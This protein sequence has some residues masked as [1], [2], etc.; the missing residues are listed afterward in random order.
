YY[1]CDNSGS[2]SNTG[3]QDSPFKTIGYTVEKV[4]SNDNY[5]IHIK[6]G[7]YK[8]TGNTNLTID[9]NTPSAPLT[10]TKS[11][12]KD[13]SN[14]VEIT[15]TNVRNY[16]SWDDDDPSSAE[17]SDEILDANAGKTF[18]IDQ[19]AF[20]ILKRV[21]LIKFS[22]SITYVGKDNPTSYSTL[23]LNTDHGN[24]TKV[25]NIT[26]Q[27]TDERQLFRG[28]TTGGYYNATVENCTF[29]ANV[30]DFPENNLRLIEFTTGTE[31]SI[32][33]V[34]IFKNSKINISAPANFLNFAQYFEGGWLG[35]VDP[36]VVPIRIGEEF[37]FA[38]AT[39]NRRIIFDSNNI[40]ISVSKDDGN[41]YATLNA[42]M[43]S[44]SHA[45]FTNNNINL[46]GE[47]YLYG[48]LCT[49]YSSHN[50]I[51]NN[52]F[53]INGQRYTAGIYLT[54]GY[55]QNNTVANNTITLVS[56]NSS[57]S[58]AEDSGYPIVIEDRRYIG[59]NYPPAEYP[60]GGELINNTVIN[61]TIVVSGNNVYGIEH[62]GGTNT[63][64]KGNRINASGINPTGIVITGNGL[65]VEDNIIYI[66]AQTNNTGTTADYFPAISGGIYAQLCFNNTI[67][68]NKVVTVNGSGIT[69]KQYRNLTIIGNKVN[70]T[71]EYAVVLTECNNNNVSGNEL[72]SK[73]YYGDEAVSIIDGQNNS[74]HDNKGLPRDK[75][76]LNVIIS[77]DSL[78]VGDY[79]YVNITL[80]DE[81]GNLLSSKV[82]LNSSASVGK[83]I[84]MNNGK[85]SDRLKILKFV[86]NATILV[87]YNG[88]IRYENCSAEV[89]FT[90]LRTETILTINNP[91]DML[92]TNV[93]ITINGTLKDNNNKAISNANI[94]VT[95]NNKEYNVTTNSDGLFNVTI[96]TPSENGKYVLT[97]R[98]NGTEIY[99]ASQETITL[100]IGKIET[101]LTVNEPMD[102]V[103]VTRNMT[104]NGT[105]KDIDN[106]AIADATIK[107]KVD[108]MDEVS[109]KTN[110][111]GEYSYSFK[112]IKT[113]DHINVH[114]SYAGD[115]EYL[116]TYA[117]TWFIV[118]KIGSKISVDEIDNV[119][120]NSEINI[121]G[122]LSVDYNLNVGIPDATVHITIDGQTYTT[123][124]DENGNYIKTI[125]TPD[126][127]KT[128]TVSV[129]YKGSELYDEC[130]DSINLYVKTKSTIDVETPIIITVV[131]NDITIKGTLKD[132]NG[133]PIR[134]VTIV[135]TIEDLINTTKTNSTG[136]YTFIYTATKVDN[137]I[138]VDIKF[139]G[140][141]YYAPSSTQAT[142]T[143]EKLNSTLI[144]DNIEN[145]K[146]NASVVITGKVTNNTNNPITDANVCVTVNN[147]SKNVTTGTDGTFR[148]EF[149]APSTAKTYTV[150]A[151]YEGSEIYNGSDNETTFDVEKIDSI[152]TI[153][154]IGSVDAN[155]NVNVTGILVDSAQNAISNQEVT[156]TVNNKKYTT[157]TGSDGKYV[158]TIMSPVVTGHYDVSASYAGSDVY[159]MASAQTSMFVKEE[160]SIIAEGPISATVNST[161]TINGSLMDASDNGI[162][163][164]TI[165]VVFEGKDYTTTTN[166]DGKFTCDIM[167]TTVG[168]NIPVTVRYDGNDTYMASSEIISV[169]VEKLGSEL[170]LNPV[171]NTDINST[172]DVSG[173]L[174]EEYTQK[175][176]ANSTV[177]IIVDGI[178][179]NTVTDDNGNFKVTIKAA[180]TTGTY[181]IKAS[182]DGSD[183]Y[184][185]S[186][187]ETTF[188]VEK[189]ST[190]TTVDAVNG[191][192]YEKVNLTAHITDVNGNNVTGGKVVF[193][194]NGVEVT[195]NNGNVIYAN[196]TGGV[197]TI[198]KEAPRVWHKENTTIVATYLGND[199]YDDSVSE[200]ADVIITLRTANIDVLTNGTKVKVGDTTSIIAHV[201]YNN[202]LVNE[203]KVIFKLNGKTLKDDDGNI[204]FVKVENGVAKLDYTITSIYSAKEYT[205]TAVFSG[206]DYNRV[207][208]ESH[209]TVLRTNTHIQA[210]MVNI[211]SN[212]ATVSIKIFDEK[213]NTVQRNTKVTVKVNGKTFYNQIIVSNGVANLN[214]N[215]PVSSKP[216]NITIISGENSV[217]ATST[218]SFMF[219]NTVKIPTKVTAT[220]KL[221]NNKTATVSVKINDNNNKPVTGNTKV[222]V[223]LN[224]KTQANAI[225]VNGVADIDMIPPTIKG[226]YTLVVM[227]G[228]TSIYEKATT[229]T[230]LKV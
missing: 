151:K 141:N 123:T 42:I 146:I 139:I 9:N 205:L 94:S 152:I 181:T 177:T 83:I 1:V 77:P 11:V 95:F 145:V 41:S 157:T 178:S 59:G 66:T 90:I 60:S 81:E 180:A 23:W 21:N 164:A 53:Q 130:D 187:D 170:T 108:D 207:A 221:V 38:R 195:D 112:T 193:S 188:D 102:V 134:D 44:S 27:Y 125:T 29:N 76:F 96:T 165:T 54:G 199:A 179:Y 230:T 186:S 18:L 63:L 68:N 26:F 116:E 138:P 203:G 70:V 167:T 79:I 103:I 183:L 43:F 173:V 78:H 58:V 55:L 22:G 120:P 113:S 132:I 84:S 192:I 80:T 91:T 226:T 100:A 156:I 3:S 121:T 119:D 62:Y 109:V 118:E 107:I 65:S 175:A 215:L 67:R 57:S 213:N 209:L 115:D 142:L 47:K 198:T 30:A 114:V 33:P 124:T 93:D 98:Y 176:I 40:T 34:M 51:S 19:K 137:N 196:V 101:T 106:H 158:V 150:T 149:T 194:I 89:P 208:T 6:N 172:V 190:K 222:V 214:L 169:D 104:I 5:N 182:Y 14:V 74:V 39:N 128:Y 73:S 223:K 92:S 166:G 24:N 12:K 88:T 61:N 160:T 126:A 227:T 82:T 163:N 117:S 174:S 16:W 97:A 153:D 45:Q 210:E 111:N 10:P 201:Y 131:N 168:D 25:A 147:E 37:T 36:K 218:T 13:D 224:G 220:A 4:N 144:I 161:I 20:N 31:D 52:T 185:P 206:K 159:T 86:D 85:G 32:D 136:G 99:D 15:G 202:T 184:T 122:K 64:I 148:V 225:A 162:A 72:G 110:E 50:N 133:N 87:T 56:S 48:M 154:T 171:N 212:N 127:S 105:L 197:A 229:T 219:K 7:T 8:G 69:A 17:I 189:I 75:T 200:K 140:D 204:I 46:S 217:Y 191:V 155:S 129:E 35:T 135:M 28:E 228:E 71:D 49:S 211:T 216:Y 2:D 143:V